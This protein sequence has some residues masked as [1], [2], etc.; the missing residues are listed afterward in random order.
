[1]STLKPC[2]FRSVLFCALHTREHVPVIQQQ[3]QSEWSFS[4]SSFITTRRAQW[5]ALWCFSRVRIDW[6][7]QTSHR[8]QLDIKTRRVNARVNEHP[9]HDVTTDTASDVPYIFVKFVQTQ[10]TLEDTEILAVPPGAINLSWRFSP[11]NF[12]TRSLST[13]VRRYHYQ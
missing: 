9:A 6:V 13:D 1:M 2:H 10:P 5:D 8:F 3:Y 12:R 4:T 7:S 11:Q